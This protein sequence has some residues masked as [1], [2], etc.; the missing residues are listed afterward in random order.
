MQFREPWGA[1][2]CGAPYAQGVLHAIQG[3]TFAPKERLTKALEAAAWYSDYVAP[4][5]TWATI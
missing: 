4:P 2:G 3:H 5:W 1:V